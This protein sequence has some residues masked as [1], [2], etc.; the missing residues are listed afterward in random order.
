MIFKSYE[1]IE[2]AFKDMRQAEEAANRNLLP[3]Q[4]KIGWGD[5]WMNPQPNLD[6]LIFGYVFTLLENEAGERAAGSSDEEW[7][8]TKAG[9]LDSY[10]R[11]YRF[12]R[13]YSTVEPNG[14]LGS[15][16]ISQM[17]P[18]SKEQFAEAK[19]LDWD[20][21]DIRQLLWPASS[22]TKM[23]ASRWETD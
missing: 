12:G 18:I 1:N 11:G 22:I 5:Y 17:V 16:H 2:D 20:L 19:A 4:K 23:L 7:Q 14:E 21:D 9:L 6:L 15:T 10:E 8:Y 13:A 3:A